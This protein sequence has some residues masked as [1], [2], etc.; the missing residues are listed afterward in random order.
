MRKLLSLAFLVA[1]TSTA[2]AQTK[3]APLP[4]RRLP[5]A[6]EPAPIPKLRISIVNLLV[7]RYNPLGLEDQLRVG[8]QL[9]LY[10]NEKLLFRDNF[11]FFGFTPRL[12]PAFA[13]IGPSV[14]IQPLSILNLRFNAEVM[15]WFG[16]FDFMQSFGSPLDNYSDSAIARGGDQGRNYRATGA[17]F[18]FEPMLQLKVG[19]IALRNRFSIEY[20][21][22]R[23]TQQPVPDTVFYEPTLDTLVPT[24]GWILSNDLDLLYLSKWKFVLGVRYSVVEPLYQDKHY[25]PGEARVNDNGHQRIGPL[26]AYTFYDRPYTRFNRPSLIL[27]VNW[28]LD[29]RWRTGTDVNQGIPYAV[30]AFAFTSD[31]IVK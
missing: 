11:V 24:D 19:P 2:A 9:R 22:L 30:L 15:Q 27:I 13:K 26:F 16:S 31:I 1:L 20:W 28:Y 18:T 6:P 12:N 10:D 3:F 8:P 7:A 4:E 17:H 29:H 21:N 5:R 25:R 23:L 14:E